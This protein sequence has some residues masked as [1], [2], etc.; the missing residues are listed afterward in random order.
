[1]LFFRLG[2]YKGLSIQALLIYV[3]DVGRRNPYNNDRHHKQTSTQVVFIFE[4]SSIRMVYC[5]I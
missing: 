4:I 2:N 1:M 3:L 5:H